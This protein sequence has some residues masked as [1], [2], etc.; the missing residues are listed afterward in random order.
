MAQRRALFIT[1]PVS[2]GRPQKGPS[3]GR[4]RQRSAVLSPHVIAQL[5]ETLF[6]GSHMRMQKLIFAGFA[7]AG[8]ASAS[9]PALA[10]TVWPD[11]DFEWYANVGRTEPGGELVPGPRG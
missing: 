4:A 2:T 6:G 3:A 1:R 8:L 11:V 5:R 7:A 9:I 10:W